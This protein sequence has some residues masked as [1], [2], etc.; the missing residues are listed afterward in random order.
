M[1]TFLLALEF[2][3]YHHSIASTMIT[4]SIIAAPLVT[5]IGILLFVNYM[6]E[7]GPPE[8]KFMLLRKVLSWRFRLKHGDQDPNYEPRSNG[9][10]AGIAC[11]PIFLRRNSVSESPIPLHNPIGR[12]VRGSHS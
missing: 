2:I 7:S 6:S 9:L 11:F 12:D 4:L 1:I 8:E 5:A 10:L 3:F